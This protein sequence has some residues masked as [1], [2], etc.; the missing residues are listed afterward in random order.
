MGNENNWNN[1]ENNSA[2][3]KY[4][5]CV[6]CCLNNLNEFRLSYMHLENN[7]FFFFGYA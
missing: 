4:F 3:F 1:Y 5:Y 6:I 7:D 2:T